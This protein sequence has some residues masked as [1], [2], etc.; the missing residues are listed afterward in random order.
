MSTKSNIAVIAAFLTALASPA[1]ASNG[2]IG[3]SDRGQG[4]SQSGRSA[5][6]YTRARA[7]VDTGRESRQH[8]TDGASSTSNFNLIGHN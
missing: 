7:S 8:N 3:L 5:S 6:V 2:D 4:G 1:S